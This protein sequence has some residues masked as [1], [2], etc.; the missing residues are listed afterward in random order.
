M[1]LGEIIR[2]IEAPAPV[3]RELPETTPVEEPD[4]QL[5]EA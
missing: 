4:E 2:E 5:I 3:E 1:D